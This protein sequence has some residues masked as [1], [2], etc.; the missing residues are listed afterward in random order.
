MSPRRH[1]PYATII[2]LTLAVIAL[3]AIGAVRARQEFLTR[4][5]P[6]EL[7]EP[8][9]E[10]GA[11]LGVNVNLE[12]YEDAA[13]AENLTRIEEL[14]I[15]SV[16]Q[17][18]Y[19]SESFDWEKSDRIV[20]AVSGRNLILVPLLDGNPSNDFVAPDDPTVFAEWAGAF[21]M[22]YGDQLDYYAIWDEPNLTS[23]WGLQEIN[24]TEYA[25]ILSA[26]AAAIRAADPQAQIILAP[27]A[28]T[29]ETGPYNLADP[30]YLEA[31]YEAGAAASFDIV[32]AKPYGFES[33]PGDR[34]VDIDTLNFSRAI[35]LHDVMVQNGDGHKAMWAGNWGWNSLPAGWQG[36]P[37]IWGQVDEE[38]QARWTAE[39]FERARLE[40]PWMG[41][42]FLENWQ[43]LA[44]ENDPR[45]GFSVAGRKTEQ[46]LKA[47]TPEANLAF[48]GFRPADE[49]DPAQSYLGAWRFS[50]DFGADAGQTGD[51]VALSFWGTDIGLRVRRADFRTRLYATVD[52]RPANA[53]P[54]DGEG[55]VLVLNA[56]GTT[57]DY[58]STEPIAQNLTPGEHEL[59]IAALRAGP[60]WALSGFSVGYRPAT[61]VTAWLYAALSIAA[62]SFTLLAVRSGRKADWGSLGSTLRNRFGRLDSGF[63]LALTALTAI[64]VALSGWLTWGEHLA[65]LYRRLGDSMQL[66]LTASTAAVFYFAPSFPIYLA[67][68]LVLFLLIYLRPAWGLALVAFTIPLYVKPKPLLGYRFSPVEVFLLITLAAVLLRVLVKRLNS[69]PFLPPL[70]RIHH[71]LATPDFAVLALSATATLSLLFTRQLDVATNEW[72]VLMI[73]SAIFYFLLRFVRLDDREMRTVLDAFVLGG[74]AIAVIGLWQFATG[75]NLIT[76]EGG[77]MRLR[78]VYGSPNN[79]ALYLGRIL[80]LLLATVLIGDGRRRKAYAAILVPVGLAMMLT[81]SKGAFFL[82]I[83]ASLLVVVILWRRSVGGR[84]WPWLLGFAGLGLAALAV[85]FQ[86]PQLAGRQNPQGATGFFRL[87]LWQSSVN[88][89]RDHPIFGVGLDNFLYEY[90]GRYILD[91]A[92]QEP[93]LSHPHN[94]ILDFA[95]RLGL[96]GLLAGGWLFWSFWKVAHGL[97]KTVKREWQ[98]VAIGLLGSLAYM[99]AHGLVDHSFFL[100]D[101]AYAFYLLLATAVWLQKSQ[102]PENESVT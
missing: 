35:L 42:M 82:G 40:W 76:S 81:Y 101:L 53:L 30:L 1:S 16:K 94:I 68:A 52:G 88:M 57:G 11:R 9:I 72:R 96:L 19:F 58:L 55:S 93:N 25:A 29:V 86:V 43:P 41:L 13:L 45:W 89:F 91:S 18:F 48:P 8:V 75:Q 102:T 5:I 74:L 83:P 36:E 24:A 21:A 61:P 49:T 26:S 10:G 28:P 12:R 90:R 7:P 51:R 95:T 20:E 78:S 38:V 63:Q 50:P 97:P 54:D 4:G 27:L 3:L 69:R 32:S 60:Q 79:V 98:P 44:P 6:D 23:H 14:G 67:S 47:Y 37:S 33:G 22:R 85:A 87:N 73:E 46:M 56:T 31:L 15:Q 66:T 99:I 59:V 34:T 71:K 2:F 92:W 84:L 17:S 80:P 64:L 39:G 100:V 65:G 70:A 77:L 62:I